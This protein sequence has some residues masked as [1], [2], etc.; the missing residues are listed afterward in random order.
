V[1]NMGEVSQIVPT[2]EAVEQTLLMRIGFGGK[3]EI[4]IGRNESNDISLDGLQ[5][6]NRHARLR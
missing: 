5:I 3:N 6:S 2:E 1:F 4:L